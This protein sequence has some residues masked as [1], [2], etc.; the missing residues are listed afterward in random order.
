MWP[1]DTPA[2]GIE[3]L[4]RELSITVRKLILQ[5]RHLTLERASLCLGALAGSMS[6]QGLVGREDATTPGPPHCAQN[7]A[8]TRSKKWKNPS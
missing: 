1:S 6:T 4:P 7:P 3:F 8:M 2:S 5:G